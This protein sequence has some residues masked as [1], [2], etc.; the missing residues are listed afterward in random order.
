MS[1]ATTE[2]KTSS[3]GREG[4]ESGYD[5]RDLR[6]EVDGAERRW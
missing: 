4:Q 1:E 6:E 3:R 2:A 5:R